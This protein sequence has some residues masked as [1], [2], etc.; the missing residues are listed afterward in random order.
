MA[1]QLWAVN[2]L[3]GYMYSNEL[4]DILRRQVQPLCKFRQFQDARDFTEKGLHRGQTFTWDVY[5]NVT[6]QGT[7]LTETSTIPQTNFTIVQGTGT[8]TEMGNS[9]PYTGMLDDMSKHPVQEIINKALKDD[10]R[11]ALDLQAYIQF[12]ST[13]L[14]VTPG[15]AGGAG[16][17]STSSIQLFTAGTTTVTNSVAL[18]SANW[19]NIIDTMKVRNI[20]PYDDDRYFSIAVT[21]TYRPLRNQ[22]EGVYQYREAGFR[23]IYLGEIGMY[24][25][26]R[27]IEQSNIPSGNPNSTFTTW[28]PW[29]VGASDWCF[30]F[31]EDTVM[32]A[33][34]VP[35]EIRGAIP[36]DYGRSRGIAWYYL[37]GSAI[38]QTQANNARIL[39]WASAV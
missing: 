12:Y 8:V 34:V 22:L 16:G 23:M 33:L 35:E 5:Q 18:G 1:G 20:P 30:F 3:G 39:L 24:E 17:S 13:P 11:K 25:G 10:A 27:M 14:L 32:E 6:Q 38:S 2:T 19:K 9:V 21:T 26:C 15:T 4:S 36:S 28:T 29:S 7:T 37:G 31:G